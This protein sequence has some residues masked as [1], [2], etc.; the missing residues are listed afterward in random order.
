MAPPEDH[1]CAWKTEAEKLRADL[2]AT[3]A[4]ADKMRAQLD[5]LTRKVFGK[6]SEKMPPMEREV[7]RDETADPSETREKRRRAAELRTTR[8]VSE[9]VKV[10]LAKDDRV[11]AHC[12]TDANVRAIGAGKECSVWHWVPGFFRR[13][14]YVRET[15]ACSCGNF[16]RTAPC[17]DK[18]TTSD[19]A[20]YAP[21]FVAHMIVAKCDD[22]MP[23][24]RLEKQYER[25]GIPIARSTMG[26][27]FHRAAE[28]L[29]PLADA[30]VKEIATRPVVHADETP[31]RLQTS[32]SRAYVWTFLADNLVA[33]RFS[34]SRS[35]KTPCEV[36]GTSTGHLV[37]DA[38]TGYNAVTCAAGRT[39]V[40]CWA[41]V[42]RKF[43]DARKSAPEADAMLEKITALYRVE[44]AAKTGKI[45]GSAQH[46]ELRRASS[47]AIVDEVRSWLDAQQPAHPPKSPLGSAIRYALDNWVPLTRFLD[48][49]AV[50]LDNNAAEG[51]LR[52][53]ALIRKNSLFAYD[54]EKG[55][56]LAALMS[57]VATCEANDVNPVA[58]LADVLTRL[59]D[60]PASRVAELLP[61]HWKPAQ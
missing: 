46:L 31:M 60:H 57:L 11:C 20:R 9:D 1:S 54:E 5:A 24:Y 8:A 59:G 37:V 2:D 10:E 56:N 51:A 42:R 41:H 19:K 25:L 43:F 21:S 14:R 28:D 3:R 34:A 26:D 33:Y 22:A 4:V 12:G 7:R 38:Y 6:T 49:S 27:L 58:Y 53:V 13:T 36:L 50:P 39:R 52:G 44:R 16:V 45:A 15:V 30:L 29:A 17:P 61:H 23:L 32:K 48:D 47:K 55:K 40:G 18:G 35:G